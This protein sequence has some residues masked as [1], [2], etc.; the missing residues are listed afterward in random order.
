MHTKQAAYRSYIVGMRVP[1]NSIPDALFWDTE[2]PFHFVR[3]IPRGSKTE[4]DDVL[5]VGGEDHK[6]GQNEDATERFSRLETWAKS[7]FPGLGEREWQWSGQVMETIDGL[8]FIGRNPGDDHVFI[9]TGDCG[10]G[11]THGTIAGLLIKD[12]I[13]GRDNPWKSLY[14][15]S[16]K[17]VRAAFEFAKE[18]LNVAGQYAKWVTPGEVSS[19]DKIERGSGGVIRKGLSKIAVYRDPSGELHQRSA[20]CT[21]LG[22]IVAWNPTEKSWD[23]PCHGSRF[24]PTGNI[25]NGPAV[26]PLEPVEEDHH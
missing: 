22:C 4:Q 11:L 26:K 7:I 17:S 2:D 24:G 12:L 19:V 20:V 8:A 14:D 23:C 21:H 9:A 15:P 25:L 5:I 18:N 6:T 13:L 10:M 16:R 3:L 1:H